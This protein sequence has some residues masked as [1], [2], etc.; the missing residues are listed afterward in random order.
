[1][2]VTEA[3]AADLP[4]LC[5]L[6]VLLF[7]QEAEFQPDAARQEA[8]L[9]LV[10]ADPKVGTI[11]VLRATDG[12]PVGMVLLLYTVSTFLGKRAALLEDFVVDPAHRG[13]G[14]GGM[15]LDAAIARAKAE[16]CA[17]I[18]LLTDVDNTGAQELYWKKGF[19]VS[20]MRAMRLSL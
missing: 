4:A 14:G 7:E 3:A 11:L 17:R 1:M 20:S 8:G 15:L 12:D 5:R 13:H 10:L 6:L 18:T 9:R 16:G 2:H 19:G